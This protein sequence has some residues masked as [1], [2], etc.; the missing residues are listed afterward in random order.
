M[1][2]GTL[3]GWYTWAQRTADG[4][5]MD[6]AISQRLASA[7]AAIKRLCHPYQFEAVTQTDVVLDAPWN[8]N[9]LILPLTP[10][11]TLTSVYY[12]PTGLGLAANF[13]STHLLT[14]NVDYQLLIDLQPEGW[15]KSGRV[16]RLNRS[17]WGVTQHRPHGRLASEP[18]PGQG[19][20]KVTYAAGHTS[21]PA[22]V[23]EALYIM[24]S[25][26]YGRRETGAP[27]ASESWNARSVSYSGPLTS[28]A[29]LNHP[30]VQQLLAPYVTQI[31][32]GS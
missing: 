4:G 20:V 3:A 21:V 19:M 24:V 13:D 9:V 22:D 10:V 12:N 15:S 32:L 31:R 7:E 16:R 2:L 23:V 25:L 29:A 18:T 27:A 17:T 6:G 11:R 28:T 8:S 26:M 30:D 1:A 14:A 5:A